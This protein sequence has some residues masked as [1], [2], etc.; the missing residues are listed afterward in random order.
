MAVK[1]LTFEERKRTWLEISTI[2]EAQ[3]DAN[4]KFQ[5]E[6]QSGVPQPGDIAPDF[7]L[8]LLDKDPKLAKKTVQLSALKGKP[9]ALMFGSYT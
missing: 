4:W 7:E 2:D 3:F 5:S 8:E 9:V 6:R 1:N